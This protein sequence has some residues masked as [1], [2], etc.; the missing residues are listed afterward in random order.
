M[1]PT[2]GL[3]GVLGVGLFAL[4]LASCNDDGR[5]LRPAT[6]EQNASVSTVAPPTT[7]EPGFDNP[8]D[9]GIDIGDDGVFDTT[10]LPV[11]ET[12]PPLSEATVAPIA[13]SDLPDATFDTPIGSSDLPPGSGGDIGGDEAVLVGPWAQD[14]PIEAKYTCSDDN[15]SPPLTWSA[16][17]EGTIEIGISMTDT[18]APGFI[19]WVMAGI[20]PSVTSLAEAEVPEGAIVGKNSVGGDGYYGPCPPVGVG[21]HH[22]VITVHYLAQMTELTTGALAEDLLAAIDDA[23]FNGASLVG[24]YART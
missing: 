16:A 9:Q 13:S 8:V 11:L 4:V 18:D 7:L 5:T 21:E 20:D 22:Y 3:L 10:T 2:H 23:T 12:S 14:M 17:P 24:T 6:P 15:N 1:T 19:H